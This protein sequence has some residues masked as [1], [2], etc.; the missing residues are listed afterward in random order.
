MFDSDD[1]E[2]ALVIASG[3]CFFFAT[4]C[5]IGVWLR[6]DPAGVVPTLSM[7]LLFAYIGILVNGWISVPAKWLACG[8][9]TVT[10]IA[11]G[12]AFRAMMT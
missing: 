5:V 6:H 1:R 7:A 10:L 2:F 3:G 11:I 4:G 8:L 9:A 12:V